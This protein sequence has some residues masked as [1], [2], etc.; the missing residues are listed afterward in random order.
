[1][2]RLEAIRQREQAA[3]QGPWFFWH[4]DD[5]HS[6]NCYGVTLERCSHDYV[7]EADHAEHTVALTLLQ[8]PRLASPGAHSGDRGWGD[9]DDNSEFIAHARTDVPLLLAA[10]EAAV[11]VIAWLDVAYPRA[12]SLDALRSALGPLLEPEG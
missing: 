5:T 6:M 2:N 10:V 12:S 1:M 7:D 4:G 9:W 11:D 3:T 8:E